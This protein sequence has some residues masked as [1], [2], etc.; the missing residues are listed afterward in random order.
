MYVLDT[1]AWIYYLLN[2]LPKELD[3]IFASVEKYNDVMFVPTIVLN[4]CIHIIDSGKI[5][6]DYE[7]L[8]SKF[9]AGYNFIVV[10]LDLEITKIVPRIKLSELHDRI[11]VA[12]AKTLNATLITK[13]EEIVK[14]KLV[15]TVWG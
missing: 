1:H 4:E 2:K 8:F 12:T 6:M 5:S 10:P 7:E 13:D 15:K 14:S 11:I 3:N 9:D